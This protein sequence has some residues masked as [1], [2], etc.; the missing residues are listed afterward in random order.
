MK[1]IIVP[2][3]FSEVADSAIE[4]AINI[5]KVLN[6][7]IILLNITRSEDDVPEAHIKLQAQADKFNKKY[8]VKLS[9]AVQVGDIFDR[10]PLAAEELGGEIIIMGTHGLR[11][12]MQ[13]IVGGN[14]IRIMKGSDMPVIVTQSDN[15]KTSIKKIIVSLDLHMKTKQSLSIARDVANRF[16]AEVHIVSPD[17]KDEFLRNRVLRNI[18]YAEE[19]FTE[20]GVAYKT[21]LLDGGSDYTKDVIKYAKYNDI[22][23][24]CILN[25]TRDQIIHAFGIDEEQ[26]MITNDAEIPVLVVNLINVF[27]EGTAIFTH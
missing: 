16:G 11:G 10:I 6:Y 1:K 21:T 19:Y 8:G 22:D 26:K 3:D 25:S 15:Q 14:A 17:E 5:N 27:Q 7:E 23:L 24:I 12:L 13:F 4:Y 2:S 18:E 20:H 9:E